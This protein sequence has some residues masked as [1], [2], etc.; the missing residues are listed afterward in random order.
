ML[1]SPSRTLILDVADADDRS[2]AVLRALASTPRRRI[3]ALLAD[4]LKNVSEIARAL[5]MPVSTANLHVGVLEEAGL[6]LS[7]HRPASRGLQKVCTRAYDS[8]MVR[9]PAPDAGPT[10]DMVEV[11]MPVGSYVDVDVTPSCGLASAESIIGMFDDPSS[12]LDPGRVGAQLIWF[13][14]GYV[15]YRFPNRLPPRAVPT[16]IEVSCEV[17]SEAPLHH[18]DW[19]SDISLTI[20]SHPVATWTSPADFGGQRGSLSPA[21]WDAHNSQYGMLKVWKVDASAG[22]IDGVRASDT[23][24][25]ALDLPKARHLDVTL[26]V[27]PDAEHVGGMNL[28]GRSFGN[29][30]QDI[31]LRIRYRSQRDASEAERC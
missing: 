10:G 12:F 24:L 27:S 6:L 25:D 29:Y 21:W 5:D 8:V 4:Q 22:W 17:C 20:N 28:F 7:E 31:V 13:H 18:D 2:D 11:S 9:L 19:P 3:L 1:E 14:H 26:S 16:S 23:T 30:P 15:T